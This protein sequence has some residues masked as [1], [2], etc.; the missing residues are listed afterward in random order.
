MVLLIDANVILDYLMV[1]RPQYDYVLRLINFC[2]KSDV[3]MFAAFHSVSIIWYTLRKEYKSER[4]KL[5]SD[6]TE[7]FTV[8]SA[9][10]EEVVNAIKNESFPDFEDC[11]QEKCALNIGADFIVTNNIKDFSASQIPAVTPAEI[12]EVIFNG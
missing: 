7:I 11:L 10:H 5:L 6:M 9:S 4:R 12:L 3:K 8:T 2:Q 1:R